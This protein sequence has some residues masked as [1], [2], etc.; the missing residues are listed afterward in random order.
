MIP[1][2]I[3]RYEVREELGRGGMAT[4]YRAHDPSFK[5]DVALKVLPREFLH[6]PTFKARFEREA[7]TIASLEHPAIVPVYDFGEEDGQPFLV[8][9]LLQGGS[10]ADRIKK[11]VLPIAEAAA[12]LAHIAPGLDAAHARGVIHRDLKPGNILFDQRG[13]PAIADFGIAK[14][15]QA[16]TTLSRN[17]FMGTPAY[18]SPEQAESESDIDGRSD[19]YTLGVI[20][21]EML[22]GQ[23]PYH[24]DTPVGLAI[25]HIQAPVP[26]ILEANPGLPPSCQVVIDRA[27]AKK[28]DERYATAGE[29]AEALQ[30]VARGEPFPAPETAGKSA[31]EAK[32]ARQARAA[33]AAQPDTQ[34]L[35][36]LD[37]ELEIGPGLGREYP[38]VV[39]HSPAGEARE[40]MKLPF[41]ELALESRLDKLQ[42]ALLRSG[43]KRRQNL[44]PEEQAVQNLG[45]GLFDALFTGAVRERYSVSLDQARREHAGLRLKLRIQPPELAT[46][47]WEFL[48]DARQSKYVCLS[49][50]TPIV[51]Y[52]EL[53]QS[54]EPL[55]VTAPLRI[56]GMIARPCNLPAL[57]VDRERQRVEQAVDSLRKRGL[58]DLTWLEG[59]T[60]R[61]LQQAM[62]GG[63][64]HIFHFIGHGG[65][66]GNTDEGFIALA[67]EEGRMHQLSATQLGRLLDDHLPLRLALLNACEGARGS[68]RDIFSS[69]ASILIRQGIPA[70]VAM[71][72]AITDRAAIEF[73]RAF[74]EAIADEMPVD[75]AVAEAR[76]AISRAVTNTLEWGTPV[77]YMRAPDGVL[78]NVQKPRHKPGKPHTPRPPTPVIR[79]SAGEQI[80]SVEQWVALAERNWGEAVKLLYH[81]ALEKWLT[82]INRPDL[83]REAERIRRT[84]TGDRSMG[85]EQF[86]RIAGSFKPQLKSHAAT[87]LNDVMGD[88]IYWRMRGQKTPRTLT[89]EI[90]NQGRGYLHGSVVS[91]VAWIEVPQPRFGC[92]PGAT[93]TVDIV[94]HPDR[95]K[96]WEFSLAPLDFVLE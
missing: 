4:V 2:K 10:L 12:I 23:Q 89:F 96:V 91:K 92:L 61:D 28:R 45:Q 49:R 81:S 78:F 85:L 84:L 77:L 72:Y 64:W 31:E 57:D 43:G 63:P 95:R 15:V 66:D 27:M 83:A 44:L 79:F 52:L 62:R 25:Q 32:V 53:P 76:K 58:V 38:V 21:Y 75:A 7:Q 37:F 50:H 36:Y 65:F 42:L 80:D 67:D 48:Y 74:Y 11:G 30:A 69:T 24:A 94:I 60:W 26:R 14:L 55:A 56:L 70:V 20:L 5:R 29:M 88:L 90:K 54:L 51:R 19:I 13:D 33:E 41:D 73:A 68:E 82:R 34:R 1:T 22:T 87:N 71:R 39:V 8:M 40:T 16:G 86:Q 3:G 93:D 6:A 46:L 59:Q 47:P 9:R 35:H 18:M 17:L